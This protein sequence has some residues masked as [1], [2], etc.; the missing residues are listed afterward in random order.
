M[1]FDVAGPLGANPAAAM[2]VADSAVWIDAPDAIKDIVPSYPLLWAGFGVV[3]TPA[4]GV[5]VWAGVSGAV[6]AW[7]VVVG[8]DTVAY[9]LTRGTPMRLQA[10][11]RRAGAVVARMDAELTG[12]GHPTKARLSVPSRPARLDLTFTLSD[13]TA[14]FP[15][16]VWRPRHP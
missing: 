12:P 3:E 13:S 11:V 16:D 5:T 7:R 8:N 6:V 1:R 9:A 14:R 10:E 15:A 4:K 2:V